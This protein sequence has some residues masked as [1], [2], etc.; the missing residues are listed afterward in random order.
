MGEAEAEDG[1]VEEVLGEFVLGVGFGGEDG[2]DGEVFNQV[3]LAVVEGGHGDVAGG[4]IEGEDDVLN[5]VVVELFADGLEEPLVKLLADALEIFG[6]A[7][8]IFEEG[9]EFT[10]FGGEVFAFDGDFFAIEDY[11]SFSGFCTPDEPEFVVEDEGIDQDGFGFGIGEDDILGG[12][13]E[14]AGLELGGVLALLLGEEFFQARDHRSKLLIGI[15]TLCNELIAFRTFG[16]FA[17][18]ELE[19]HGDFVIEGGGDGLF[20]GIKGGAWSFRTGSIAGIVAEFLDFEEFE[21]LL[22]F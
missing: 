9:L 3:L 2:G 20:Y 7:V 11:G 6:V 12:A 22:C 14:F 16:L 15:I 4:A 10:D 8:G 17:L 5:A 1:I 18:G 21:D 13:G 19:S